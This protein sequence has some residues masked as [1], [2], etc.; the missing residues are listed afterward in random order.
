MKIARCPVCKM[1]KPWL[2]R[3]HPLR[4]IFTKYYVECRSCHCCG[5]TKIGYRRAIKWWN[6]WCKEGVNNA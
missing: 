1:P 4:G 2:V 5:K 3:I 6:K